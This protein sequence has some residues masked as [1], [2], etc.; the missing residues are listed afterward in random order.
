MKN[1][2]LNR[3][4]LPGSGMVDLLFLLANAELS[5]I[6]PKTKLTDPTHAQPL[7]P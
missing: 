3:I 5:P 1:N 4:G 7:Y 2:N 6:K